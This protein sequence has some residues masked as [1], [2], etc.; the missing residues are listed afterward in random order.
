MSKVRVHNSRK[1]KTRSG[2]FKTAPHSRLPGAP[3]RN[4]RA[5]KSTQINGRARGHYDWELLGFMSR[6]CTEF[7]Q[8]IPGNCMCTWVPHYGMWELK[9]AYRLCP[10]ENHSQFNNVSPV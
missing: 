6:I 9:F 1:F 2:D 3:K 5:Q 4:Q 8:W 7:P 10:C